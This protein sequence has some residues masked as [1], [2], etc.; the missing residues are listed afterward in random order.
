MD[1]LLSGPWVFLH[2]SPPTSCEKRTMTHHTPRKTCAFALLLSLAASMAWADKPIDIGS[3]RELMV[4]DYLI[5]RF[6]GGARLELHHPAAREVVLKH[7]RPWSG[8]NGSYYG[9]FKDGDIYRMYYL[10][11]Q[12]QYMPRDAKPHEMYAC[13]AESNDG[14]HWKRPELGIVEHNGSKKNNIIWA[15]HEAHDF[16]PFKDS[17]PDCKAD[18]KYKAVGNNCQG[19]LVA[20]KSPDGI[21]WTK[22][23]E[24]PIITGHAFDS[25]NQAF[26][27]PI[28]KQYRCYLRDFKDGRRCILVATSKDFINWTKAEWLQYTGCPKEQL[29]INVISRYYRA[30]HFFVGFPT[31]YTERGWLPSYNHLPDLEHRKIR[32]KGSLRFGTAVTEDLFMSSRDGLNFH[33][34]GEAFIR[35][36][37]QRNGNWEY[38][39]GYQCL[40]LFET[41]SD[42]PGAENELSFYVDENAWRPDHQLRRYTIR[43]D[44]FVSVNAPR[45]GGGFVTKPL[46][47]DGKELE[48]N[49]SS[50][51]AG[52]IKV[53]IQ[54][55]AGKPIEG[56]TLADADETFGDTLAR[57]ATWKGK[58]DVGSLAGKPVRLRFVMSDADLYSFR[59]K[60]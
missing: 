7:D 10:S 24:K 36:G 35:P 34:W 29:Y 12:V 53:E 59:F 46:V 16:T 23:Q 44:G 48:M 13:Y 55:A 54:D 1:R 11:Y 52:S 58:S 50:S 47:F 19:G 42:R 37:P 4:D 26:W 9:A 20:F 31:R 17:N 57:A 8:N 3:R 5:D 40:G 60:K 33:R 25:Q 28:D 30:P 45:A 49:F 18:A 41:P 43:I 38:G 21:H 14:I 39:D 22:L 6:E 32:S 27:D 2:T 51:A 15:G 56:F